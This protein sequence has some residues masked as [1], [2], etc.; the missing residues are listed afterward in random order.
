MNRLIVWLLTLFL[1]PAFA[2]SGTDSDPGLTLRI[3]DKQAASGELVCIPVHARDFDNILTMQYSIGWDNSVLNF[4]KVSDFGLPALS[5]ENFG[6]PPSHPDRLTV[7]WFEPNLKAVSVPDDA[8][9]FTVCFQVVGASGKSCDVSIVNDPTIVEIANIQEQV[10]Q[11]KLAKGK[12]E[13]Q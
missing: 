2:C 10:I 7:S 13:V 8:V 11:P 5:E 4:V 3:D 1:L 9:L 6:R 12:V